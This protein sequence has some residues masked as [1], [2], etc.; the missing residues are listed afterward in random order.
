MAANAASTRMSPVLLGGL[1]AS[2]RQPGLPRGAGHSCSR[3]ASGRRHSARACSAAR[4]PGAWR[5]RRRRPGQPSRTPASAHQQWYRSHAPQT[6]RQRCTDR[7]CWLPWACVRGQ[8]RREL[9]PATRHSANSGSRAYDRTDRTVTV[10]ERPAAALIGSNVYPRLARGSQV[11]G[12]LAREAS[13][14]SRNPSTASHSSF[15]G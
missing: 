3:Q 5:Q 7:G 13:T 9:T 6:V 4:P 1:P 12:L 11:S 10:N 14:R 8:A 15:S 2:A